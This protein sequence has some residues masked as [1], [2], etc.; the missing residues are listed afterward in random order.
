MASVPFVQFLRPDG[1]KK[2]VVIDRPD[3]IAKAADKIR[4]HG[5][6]FEIEQLMDGTISMT[7]S[8]KDDD[9]AIKV[10]ENQPGTVAATVDELIASFDLG[11]ALK[12]RR[13]NNA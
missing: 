7:I 10:C 4:S 3:N 13:Q 6:R 5:F 2:P 11:N 9:Y 12:R 1:H 8:D